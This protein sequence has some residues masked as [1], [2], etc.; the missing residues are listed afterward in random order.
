MTWDNGTQFHS[1]RFGGSVGVCKGWIGQGEVAMPGSWRGA[2]AGL[3]AALVLV[4]ILN[5]QTALGVM[6]QAHIIT[7]LSGLGAIGRGGAWADHFIVGVLVWGLAYGSLTPLMPKW[8]DWLK[9]LA[10]GVV[11]WLLMMLI[12]MPV[13]GAG[14]FARKLGIEAAAFMLGLHLIFG[15]VMGVSYS[16]L[17]IWFPV[18]NDTDTLPI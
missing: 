8:P 15:I 18:R 7:L 13:V 6:P 4:V 17:A 16:L 10:F 1:R 5:V 14:L 3:V 12:F 9:G 2:V 11:A